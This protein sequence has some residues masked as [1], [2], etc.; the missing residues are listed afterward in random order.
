MWQKYKDCPD[1]FHPGKKFGEGVYCTSKIK[2]AEKYAGKC[3]ING[4]TYKTVLM[5]RVKPNALRHCDVCR[6]SWIEN[7]WVV[8]ATNDEI[9][10]YRILYKKCKKN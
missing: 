8:N 10:P 4:I 9:S 5:V 6:D 2:V 7:Y 1:K 3:N